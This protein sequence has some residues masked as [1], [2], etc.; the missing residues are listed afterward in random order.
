[1]ALTNEA[2]KGVSVISIRHVLSN[3]P[4]TDTR[5]LS[6]SSEEIRRM[7]KRELN[8]EKRVKSKNNCKST[9]YTEMLF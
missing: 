8:K 7:Y 3:F 6:V 9:N 5:T 2:T 4:R 1:M